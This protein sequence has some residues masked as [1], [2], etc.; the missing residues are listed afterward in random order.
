VLRMGGGRFLVSGLRT[1][2][3]VRSS[4]SI[5]VVVLSGEKAVLKVGWVFTAVLICAREDNNLKV[6]G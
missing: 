2:R 4:D 1:L 6:V 3:R 5:V